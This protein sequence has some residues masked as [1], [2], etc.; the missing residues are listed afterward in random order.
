MLQFQFI[1]LRPVVQLLHAHAAVPQVLQFIHQQ[2][3]AG[4][5]RQRVH[6]K[7]PAVRVFFQQGIPGDQGGIDGAGNTAGQSQVQDVSAL[8]QKT[9]EVLLI[10][11]HIDL[12]SPGIRSLGHGLIEIRK[13]HGFTQI[14]HILLPCQFKMKTNIVNIPLPKLFLTQIHRG[15]AA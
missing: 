15:T 9:L 7:N 8:F 1:I 13:R 5:S 11:L 12:R 2:A 14:I 4:G 3:I 6:H 10:L